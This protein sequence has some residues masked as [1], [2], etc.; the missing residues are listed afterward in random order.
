M[1][2]TITS[3]KSISDITPVVQLQAEIWGA[4][5][6]TAPAHLLLTIAKEE[7]IVHLMLDDD[8]PI[9]FSYGFLSR[10]ESG[11][12]KLASHQAGV[13]AAYQSRGLGYRLKLAQREAAL[14]RGLAL[15]TWTYDPLQSLNARLNLHKLGAVCR[16]YIPNLYG[17]MSDAL[18]QGLPSDRFRVDWWLDSP[19]VAARLRGEFPDP[20]QALANY[21]LLNPA[22]SAEAPL[23]ADTADVCLVEIS[24][25]LAK[26]KTDGPDQAR[27]WRMQTRHIFTTLFERNYSAIDLLRYDGRSFYL[28]QRNW[29]PG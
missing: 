11:Q 28:L 6:E 8:R 13:L 24:A 7:G 26:L 29:Q 23:P 19:H 22:G 4:P 17:E 5:G 1:T 20:A 12:L 27:R 9:G 21:P 10:T 25:N 18:N 14:A 15:I 3:P 16:T 2:I